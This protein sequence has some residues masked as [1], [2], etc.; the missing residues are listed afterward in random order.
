MSQVTTIPL[1]DIFKSTMHLIVDLIDSPRRRVL[2]N[3]QLSPTASPLLRIT[4]LIWFSRID[5]N[6]P[7]QRW[8]SNH[9]NKLTAFTAYPMPRFPISHFQS[10]DP[11][12]QKIADVDVRVLVHPRDLLQDDNTLPWSAGGYQ[13]RNRQRDS[14]SCKFPAS[15]S[16]L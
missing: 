3:E 13:G 6:S 8:R 14:G 10:S 4:E 5:L 12:T 7:R 9:I 2:N 16:P 11:R 15:A 1:P